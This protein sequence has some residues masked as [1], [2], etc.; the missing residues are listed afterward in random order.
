MPLTLLPQIAL[1]VKR[2][3]LR[4]RSIVQLGCLPEKKNAAKILRSAKNE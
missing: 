1:G 2:V 3:S 4:V